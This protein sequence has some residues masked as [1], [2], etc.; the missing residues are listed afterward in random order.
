M[1]YY[2]KCL[3]QLFNERHF[4]LE[5]KFLNEQV[6]TN[7]NKSEIKNTLHSWIKYEDNFVS[8]IFKQ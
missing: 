1:T 4:Y 5:Y 8:V 6:W 2:T 3:Q 7:L